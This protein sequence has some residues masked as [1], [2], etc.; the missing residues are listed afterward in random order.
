MG[1]TFASEPCD[2]A[3][4]ER[5]IRRFVDAGTPR[6]TPRSRTPAGRRADPRPRPR[7]APRPRGQGDRRDQGE[8]VARRQHDQRRRRAASPRRARGPGR[9]LPG[10]P[11]GRR[12]RSA[13]PPRPGRGDADR[14]NPR[15]VG[16]PTRARRVPQARTQQLRRVECVRVHAMCDAF[17][18]PRPDT[19][20]GM[21]NCVTRAVEPELLPALRAL[22]MRFLAYN[23][24]AGGLLT[25]K[26]EAGGGGDKNASSSRRGRFSENKMYLDRFWRPE[27][28]AAVDAIAAACGKHEGLTV[29]DASLLWLYSHSRLDGARGDGVVLGASSE[30]HLEANLGAA[31]RRRRGNAA[32]RRPGRHRG[33]I[34]DV[35]GRAAAVLQ[36]TLAPVARA[37]RELEP[38]YSKDLP[39]DDIGLSIFHVCRAAPLAQL[40]SARFTPRSSSSPASPR[41]DPAAARAPSGTRRPPRIREPRRGLSG[42]APRPPPPRPRDR[43]TSR[44]SPPKR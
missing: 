33:G 14:A 22:D 34:R 24:L 42:R 40:R 28:F 21:Y 43:R 29:A 39:S 37:R 2:D 41:G 20:Q 17:G 1:W 18:L 9:S 31:A 32:G 23:P 26:H 15:G 10:E 44:G 27:Y 4:S 30:A 5:L 38:S 19:Y 3:V 16:D 6:S 13:L 8:S 36:G 7:R 12:R 35:R 11:R 25:G